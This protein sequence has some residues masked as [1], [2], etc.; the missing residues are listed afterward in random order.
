MFGTQHDG[1]SQDHG[2]LGAD[3]AGMQ[4]LLSA[5][6]CVVQEDQSAG[7]HHTGPLT[8]AVTV[9]HHCRKTLLVTDPR[10]RPQLHLD[11]A[12]QAK[13][14]RRALLMLNL[15]SSGKCTKQLLTAECKASFTL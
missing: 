3:D 5:A 10:S 4:T 13:R 7:T 6:S 15:L 9:C 11:R 2:H 8:I 1:S 12:L 14:I